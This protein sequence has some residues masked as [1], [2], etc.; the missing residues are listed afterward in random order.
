MRVPKITKY[1]DKIDKVTIEVDKLMFEPKFYDLGNERQ[2]FKYIS[3]IEKLCRSSLEYKEFIEYLRNTLGM[4]FCSFFH[5][6]SRKNFPKAKIRIEIHHEPFTLYDIVAIVLNY[7]LDNDLPHDMLTIAE[8]V[9][10]LHYEGKVGLIPLS[11][12]VHELVHN[13]KLFIPLQF[14]DIGF[15]D[16]YNEYKQTIK[17]MDGLTDMLQAKIHLSKEFAENPKEFIS[18]L[19]KKYIYVIGEGHGDELEHIT[20]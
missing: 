2:K 11:E 17:D 9:M 12:T 7:R 19:R 6:V 4:D 16:F 18:I 14:I 8:E 15:N 5:K 10:K 1:D 20:K 13:G 3:T